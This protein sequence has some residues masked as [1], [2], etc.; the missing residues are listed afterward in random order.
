MYGE[1]PGLKPKKFISKSKLEKEKAATFDDRLFFDKAYSFHIDRIEVFMV[2]G[3]LQGIGITY[4]MDGVLMTK[5]N[6]GKKMPDTSYELELSKDEHIN[7]ISFHFVEEG[8]IDLIIKTSHNNML[9]MEEDEK[10][11][12]KYGEDYIETLDF[13]LSDNDEAL[14]GFKGMYGRT[15]KS[16]GFYKATRI[17]REEEEG[18]KKNKSDQ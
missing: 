9:V 8:I 13:N 16:L 18:A 3:F 11:R 10:Y 14:I 5:L 2:N 4:N 12:K 7:Y 15:I 1:K 6:K 17:I